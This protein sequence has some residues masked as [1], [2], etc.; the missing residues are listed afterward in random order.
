M[1]KGL[2]SFLNVIES[3]GESEDENTQL[4]LDAVGMKPTKKTGK[5]AAGKRQTGAEPAPAQLAIPDAPPEEGVEKIKG[6]NYFIAT[7]TRPP[8]VYR[9]NPF[10]VEVGL[11]TAE[12]PADKTI[13]YS[14][15][16]RVALFFQRGLCGAEAIVR[17]DWRNGLLSAQ[18]FVAGGPMALVHIAPSGR[19][20]ES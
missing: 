16:Q 20:Q 9:G 6:H 14:L 19:S 4:D 7:V 18:G 15:R 5:A 1:K 17:A 10:Q 12:P 3:E 13:C 11:A 8:R 2:V